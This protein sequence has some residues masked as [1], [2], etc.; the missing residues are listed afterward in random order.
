MRKICVIARILWWSVWRLWGGPAVAL[1]PAPE[2]RY[3]MCVSAESEKGNSPT[4]QLSSLLITVS[5][6]ITTSH[7]SARLPPWRADSRSQAWF[8]EPGLPLLH[9]EQQGSH[10]HILKCLWAWDEW[11]RPMLFRFFR[12]QFFLTYCTAVRCA[13]KDI[14]GFGSFSA[15]NRN[16][17]ANHK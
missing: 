8:V 17:P 7:S 2:T 10:I 15:L 13:F 5:H 12:R 4:L 3:W 16:P 11:F 14:N 1:P 9:E 6:S